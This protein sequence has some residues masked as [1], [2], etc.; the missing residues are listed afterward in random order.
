MALS[1]IEK[2]TFDSQID[3]HYL[4][5]IKNRSLSNLIAE[6][7]N[8]FHESPQILIIK[9]RECILDESHLSITIEVIHE[10]AL[11]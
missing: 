1:R 10:A 7:F 11:Q 5:L 6:K 9:N 2:A 3:F 8:V 4:D